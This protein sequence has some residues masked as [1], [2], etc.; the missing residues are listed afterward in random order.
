MSM[1]NLSRTDALTASG[2]SYDIGPRC[3]TPVYQHQCL[4]IMHGGRSQR[5]PLPTTLVY[6]PTG[7]NFYPVSTHFI[8]KASEDI[9]PCK[10]SKTS[11][12]TTGFIKKLPA[13]PNTFGSGNLLS[14][15]SI[16]TCRNVFKS[17]FGYFSSS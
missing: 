10:A 15:I 12:A 14:R 4:I 3:P 8:K 17:T 5:F 9:V 1:P 2:K 13:L 11:R 6:H 16:I 7:R